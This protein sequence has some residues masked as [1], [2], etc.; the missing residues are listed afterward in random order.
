MLLRRLF[1]GSSSQLREPIEKILWASIEGALRALYI[2]WRVNPKCSPITEG[3]EAHDSL[4][5]GLDTS[6]PDLG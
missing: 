2:A 3:G 1:S 4:V 6:S 5:L